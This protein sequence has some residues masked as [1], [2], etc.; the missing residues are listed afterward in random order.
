MRIEGSTCSIYACHRWYVVVLVMGM[1][2]HPRP[3]LNPKWQYK[4]TPLCWLLLVLLLV[5]VIEEVVIC[6][7]V[8]YSV[9][10]LI[11]SSRLSFGFISSSWSV[12]LLLLLFDSSDELPPPRVLPWSTLFKSFKKLWPIVRGSGGT[13]CDVWG[14]VGEIVTVDAGLIGRCVCGSMPRLRSFLLMWVFQ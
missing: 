13:S 1:H 9:G 6:S 4:H 5:L 12:K 10:K 11:E 8:G 2:L 3:S 14:L 7:T